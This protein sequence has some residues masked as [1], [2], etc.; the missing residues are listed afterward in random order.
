MHWLDYPIFVAIFF[1]MVSILRKELKAFF[2]SI[3]GYVAILVFLVVV[4]FFMWI[5]PDSNMLDYGY[6]TMD[7]FF[8]LAPWILLFLIPAITMRSFS[9]E[10]RSGTIELLFTLPLREREIILGKFLAC[11]TIVVIAILPTLLYVFS[12]SRLSIIENNIDIGGT[13]GS[14]IGLLFLCSAF[15][16]IGLFASTLSNNQVVAF[17]AAVLLNFVVFV[18]FE[19]LSHFKQFENGWDY[20]IS[21]IG[22]EFHYKSISRGLIDTRDLVYFISVSA[23]FILAAKLSLNKRKWA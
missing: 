1:T 3:V 9:E 8:D 11:L 12:I 16:A 2:S 19:T 6:A 13:I 7:K 4:G 20:I 21:Q 5:S 18:G 23:I 17:I 22:M 15:T 14:Y 10:Y